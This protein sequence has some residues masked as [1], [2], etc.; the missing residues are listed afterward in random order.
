MFSV[1][2]F[3]NLY[4]K[5]C[6]MFKNI[7]QC[8]LTGGSGQG[9]SVPSIDLCQGGTSAYVSLGSSKVREPFSG[10]TLR[11]IYILANILRIFQIIYMTT[12]SDSSFPLKKFGF[13]FHVWWWPAVVFLS[14]STQKQ[15]R[16]RICLII[17]RLVI[18]AMWSFFLLSV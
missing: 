3:I 9:Y 1:T 11:Y 10:L 8:L 5:V 17:C 2:N 6:V 4:F 18:F 16:L 12:I 15:E 7:F 14:L 13:K